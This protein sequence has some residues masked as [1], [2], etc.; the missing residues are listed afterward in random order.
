MAGSSRRIPR[1]NRRRRSHNPL[2]RGAPLGDGRIGSSWR[3]RVSS[4]DPDHRAA[5][6]AVHSL[7]P[8]LYLLAVAVGMSLVAAGFIASRWRSGNPLFDP[9]ECAFDGIGGGSRAARGGE[10]G[11]EAA[12]TGGATDRL[13]NLGP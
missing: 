4:R 7:E 9:A 12:C 2:M 8:L 5:V 13:T 6:V 10:R 1:P 11:S 3:A